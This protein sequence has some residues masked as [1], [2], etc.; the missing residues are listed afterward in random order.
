MKGSHVEVESN[1]KESMRPSS[2][3]I[4]CW[5]DHW[6]AAIMQPPQSG[7]QM[8]LKTGCWGYA[9][10]FFFGSIRALDL[11]DVVFSER[12]R[13]AVLEAGGLLYT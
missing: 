11:V 8:E 7:R 2:P 6:P 5:F 1:E 13:A 10:G 3:L 12:E 9:G 4:S